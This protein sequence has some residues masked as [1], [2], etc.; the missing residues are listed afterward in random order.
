MFPPL[1]PPLRDSLGKPLYGGKTSFPVLV[2]Y[3][4]ARV[5][6]STAE[7]EVGQLW[8]FHSPLI[9][10]CP[11]ST[12]PC[13]LQHSTSTAL[14]CAVQQLVYENGHGIAPQ[15]GVD[16]TVNGIGQ[17]DTAIQSPPPWDPTPDCRG[18]STISIVYIRRESAIRKLHCR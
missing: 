16:G 8:R 4:A 18:C 9:H 15:V 11:T 5:L 12:R 10:K 17:D 6:T 1:L 13:E 7:W 2:P 14:Y 3:R